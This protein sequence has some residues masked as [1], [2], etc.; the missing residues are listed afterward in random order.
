MGGR[1][2]TEQTDLATLLGELASRLRNDALALT[3]LAWR[4]SRPGTAE[5][6][7][8]HGLAGSLERTAK[9][10]QAVMD[11]LCAECRL[12]DVS[13]HVTFGKSPKVRPERKTKGERDDEQE[14]GQE[15]KG[16]GRRK[17][18]RR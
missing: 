5:H 18:R 17:G 4:E 11:R 16:G 2:E 6:E 13:E 7:D 3:G 8:L 12:L 15:R 10:L 1:I 9:V 14:E